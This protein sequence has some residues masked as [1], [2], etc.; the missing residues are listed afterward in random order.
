M[1]EATRVLIVEDDDTMREQLVAI[2]GSQDDF[3]VAGAYATGAG[4][5]A[6]EGA[7]EMALVDLG[8]PDTTGADVI[9]EL[10]ATRPELEVMAHTIFE[11]RQNVFEAIVAGASSYVLKGTPRDELM[12]CLREQRDG[13]SP[14]SPRIAR[15]VVAAFQRQG[16]VAD[17]HTLSARE[18]EVLVGLEDGFSY[19]EIA[20]Q[21]HVSTHTVHAH[22]KRVYEKL[23]AHTRAEA[24][25]KARL[26]GLL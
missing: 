22:I 6:H 16:S 15:S 12:A 13:G 8:L 3:R 19:K 2:V 21:L 26:R 11:D 20:S 25:T 7:F 9:R 23:H 5:L 1:K 18:H 17:K 4:A 14:M 10:K 24:L